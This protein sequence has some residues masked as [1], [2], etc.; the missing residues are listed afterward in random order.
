M[1][2]VCPASRRSMPSVRTK[3]PKTGHDDDDHIFPLVDPPRVVNDEKAQALIAVLQQAGLVAMNHDFAPLAAQILGYVM[4]LTVA[5]GTAAYALFVGP[6]TGEDPP[7]PWPAYALSIRQNLFKHAKEPHK[8]CLYLCWTVLVDLDGAPESRIIVKDR[9]FAPE[10]LPMYPSFIARLERCRKM[11]ATMLLGSCVTNDLEC[12]YHTLA[13]VVFVISHQYIP[14]RL[15][16][17]TAS[18]IDWASLANML[19]DAYDYIQLDH[20]HR[21]FVRQA[22]FPHNSHWRLMPA[23]AKLCYE[24]LQEEHECA[25]RRGWCTHSIERQM[26]MWA[27]LHT[28]CSS[29]S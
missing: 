8:T 2:L 28:S 7:P 16:W 26:G 9:P 25:T 4:G 20:P 11:T 21:R 23:F 10:V 22:L 13:C 12:A 18:T 29:A 17:M 24:A 27:S 3:C 5:V 6:V 19:E 15:M 14:H 1:P